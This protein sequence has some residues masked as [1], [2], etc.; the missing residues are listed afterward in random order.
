[1][2][3][4]LLAL[5]ALMT[6]FLLSC[7]DK[8]SNKEDQLATS[9]TPLEVWLDGASKR[10]QKLSFMKDTV[11]SFI[12]YKGEFKADKEGKVYLERV[13][14]LKYAVGGNTWVEKN[15]H[16]LYYLFD[17]KSYQIIVRTDNFDVFEMILDA[18]MKR[19]GYPKDKKGE[20][21]QEVKSNEPIP[22]KYTYYIRFK[23]TSFATG[24][25][26]NSLDI[27]KFAEFDPTY[28]EGNIYYIQITDEGL[29][30][31]YELY[32]K[33]K[34]KKAEEEKVK[35]DK[36]NERKSDSLNTSLENQFL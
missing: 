8:K 22:P 12:S 7:S 25:T 33:A 19:F 27:H 13:I 14:P 10:V 3:K 34:E 35:R 36:E 30:E 31:K 9:K 1:M 21:P 15:I 2:K 4:T 18:Y 11:G 29:K 17:K 23:S 6:I 26:E 32:E 28:D 20:Y 24:F 5:A 16:I